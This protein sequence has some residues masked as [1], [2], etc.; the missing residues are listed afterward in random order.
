MGCDMS[1]SGAGFTEYRR[2]KGWETAPFASCPPEEAAGFGAELQDVACRERRGLSVL[3]LGFGNGSFA[4]WAIDRGW[5]YV[6]T[7][8]DPVLVARAR[9]LGIDAL[10]ARSSQGVLR[11]H[12]PFD[13]VVA[14]DV[15]EH[16]HGH[17]LRALLADCRSALV[18]G[19]TMLARLPAAESPFSRGIQHGDATH[20]Q[21]IT[22]HRAQRE[23]LASGFSACMV[24]GTRLPLRGVAPMACLRRMLVKGV[25]SVVHPVVRMLM[26]DR[27]AV[28]TPNMIV[29]ARA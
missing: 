9:T 1:A 4:R 21:A 15:L 16:V 23:F 20:M 26:R 7:E 12:G 18:D 17:E 25:D 8:A 28:L 6:G 27:M 5:R 19:G 14:W 2:W 22:S 3:E 13:L 24:R 29:V 11:G 10:D